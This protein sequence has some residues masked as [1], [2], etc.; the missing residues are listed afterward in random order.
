MDELMYFWED[1]KAYQCGNGHYD[2]RDAQIVCFPF[3]C[4]SNF[5]VDLLRILHYQALHYIAI[6]DNDWSDFHIEGQ[7]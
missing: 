6:G 4:V 1:H 7:G 2:L 5:A 3:D